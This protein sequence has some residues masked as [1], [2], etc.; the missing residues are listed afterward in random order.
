MLLGTYAES[1]GHHHDHL[2]FIVLDAEKHGLRRT[3]HRPYECECG[4]LLTP[5]KLDWGDRQK[6]SWPNCKSWRDGGKKRCPECEEYFSNSREQF[7]RP[8]GYEVQPQEEYDDITDEARETVRERFGDTCIFCDDSFE[9]VHRIIPPRYYGSADPKNLVS[10]CNHHNRRSGHLFV[11]VMAPWEW[12][13]VSGL[14]WESYVSRLRAKYKDAESEQAE[15][16]VDLLGEML[17]EGKPSNPNPYANTSDEALG[18]LEVDSSED[19]KT[20][21]QRVSEHYEDTS[22]AP[23]ADSLLA[24]HDV[25]GLERD[26][27]ESTVESLLSNGELYELNDGFLKVA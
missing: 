2:V 27:A 11:D 22:G 24:L 4:T 13:K 20:V 3:Q 21:I 9:A 7:A 10:L 12:D 26:E 14:D 25:I 5:E 15:I 6:K 1:G 19:I 17:D 23:R 8:R 16:L 18:W